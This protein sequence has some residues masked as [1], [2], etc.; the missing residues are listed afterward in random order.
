MPLRRDHGCCYLQHG[1]PCQSEPGIQPTFPSEA[2]APGI[3]TFVTLLRARPRPS[4]HVRQSSAPGS[5]MEG[6]RIPS[7]CARS[8]CFP[9]SASGC[10]LRRAATGPDA[11]TPSASRK[12]ATPQR[13]CASLGPAF[14]CQVAAHYRSLAL[15]VLPRST[16][17]TV[18]CNAA[19]HSKPSLQSVNLHSGPT[20]LR[21]APSIAKSLPS[22]LLG[23]VCVALLASV[24]F[25]SQVA[26][27]RLTSLCFSIFGHTPKPQLQ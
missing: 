11:C 19:N 1:R 18:Y 12:G 15:A 24:D 13:G 5:G 25:H 14:S 3:T 10:N 17:C 21:I 23:S 8:W 27:H 2:L 4:E 6:T 22:S 20:S 16:A 26:H 9:E 7:R